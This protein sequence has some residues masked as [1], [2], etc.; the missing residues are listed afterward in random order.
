MPKCKITVLKKM[1]DEQLANE[2]FLNP[3]GPCNYFEVGQEFIAEHPQ[4]EPPGFPCPVAWAGIASYVFVLLS[5][6][7]FGPSNWGWIKDDDTMISCCTDGVRP[8]V[9]KIERIKENA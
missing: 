6:G 1:Y 7:S 8:V 5:G 9:F 2:Y 3:S 4:K